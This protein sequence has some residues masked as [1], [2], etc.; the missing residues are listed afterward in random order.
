MVAL[1]RVLKVGFNASMGPLEPPPELVPHIAR[2]RACTERTQDSTLRAIQLIEIFNSFNDA[3]NPLRNND[4]AR[5][6][7][8]NTVNALIDAAIRELITILVRMFDPVGRGGLLK[9]NRQSFLVMLDLSRVDGVRSFLCDQARRWYGDDERGNDI[10]QAI[11]AFEGALERLNTETPNRCALLRA[12]RDE[13]LAH[14]LH[15]D[16][17]RDRPINGYISEIVG[18]VETLTKACALGFYRS[19]VTYETAHANARSSADGLWRLIWRGLQNA[20]AGD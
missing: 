20:R 18:E 8:A 7:A 17:E 5:H 15:F 4:L 11:E 3:S 6:D 12:F 10:P 1:A 14:Q 19:A 16:F 2:L 13:F 9:T